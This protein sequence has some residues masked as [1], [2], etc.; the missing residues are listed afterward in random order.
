MDD[1]GRLRHGRLMKIW[2][3]DNVHLHSSSFCAGMMVQTSIF[4]VVM[5]A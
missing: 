1:A 3:A 2:F 5:L 4:T